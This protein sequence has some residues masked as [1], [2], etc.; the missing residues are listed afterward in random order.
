MYKSIAEWPEG[1]CKN[2]FG[3]SESSDTH[4]SK[5]AAEAV[6]KMLERD[7]YGGMGEIFPLKTKVV[8]LSGQALKRRIITML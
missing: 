6:C 7:G 4:Q 5:E 1:T 2:S 3:K 8:E